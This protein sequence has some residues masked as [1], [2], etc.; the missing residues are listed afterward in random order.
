VG[1]GGGGEKGD[2][3]TLRYA[4]ITVKYRRR[5][6]YLYVRASTLLGLPVTQGGHAEIHT[7]YLS[8]FSEKS[9]QRGARHGFKYVFDQPCLQ[10]SLPKH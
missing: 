2:S 9:H 1:G 4:P 10:D 7:A 8:L 5:G 6:P 3:P